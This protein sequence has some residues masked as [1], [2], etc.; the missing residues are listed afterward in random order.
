MWQA[1]HHHS[2]AV[3][4]HLQTCLAN[5]GSMTAYVRQLGQ[6]FSVTLHYQGFTHTH[7]DIHHYMDT[8][9][10]SPLF[11]RQV[12]LQCDAQPMVFGQCIITQAMYQQHQCWLGDVGN[13]SIGDLLFK[14]SQLQRSP[15]D[16]TPLPI[17]SDYHQQ[18][19]QIASIDNIPLWARRSHLYDDRLR[20]GV[21]EVCLPAL[22]H[23]LQMEYS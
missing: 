8:P 12:V 13:Q 22:S 6:S 17:D 3:P 18:L 1:I 16:I 4:P 2:M 5:T 21:I 7:A 19:H 9:A 20:V 23:R 10:A 15:I 11:V 14:R